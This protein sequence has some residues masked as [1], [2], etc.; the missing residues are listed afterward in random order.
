MGQVR[1][2]TNPSRRSGSTGRDK[3]Q[4]PCMPGL[5]LWNSAYSVPESNELD[6]MF[7]MSDAGVKEKTSNG[8]CPLNGHLIVG[9]L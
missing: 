7:V 2:R 4:F 9:I 1:T 5:D 3:Q 8:S 6:A